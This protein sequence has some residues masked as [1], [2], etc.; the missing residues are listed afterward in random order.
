M[1]IYPI[2]ITFSFSENGSF[3]SEALFFP[4]MWGWYSVALTLTILRVAAEARRCEMVFHLYKCFSNPRFGI[5]S[6]LLEENLRV[7]FVP[8]VKLHCE[9]G[10][11]DENGTARVPHE[12]ENW[13]WFHLAKEEWY[14]AIFCSLLLNDSDLWLN[15]VPFD[16]FMQSLLAIYFIA[17]AVFTISRARK[18]FGK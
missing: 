17:S 13:K 5:S 6:K 4:G 12:R 11:S 9:G 10:V 7:C 18:C 16:P 3:I 2:K 14:S 8:G 15:S 1:K